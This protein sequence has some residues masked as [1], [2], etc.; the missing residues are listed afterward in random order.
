M[1]GYEN[2]ARVSY[3]VHFGI[4]CIIHGIF[5]EIFFGQLDRFISRP[6]YDTL[7]SFINRKS[8]FLLLIK[9][10]FIPNKARLLD[11]NIISQY[12]S[13]QLNNHTDNQFTA[14]KRIW[15][16]LI[17]RTEL[18]LYTRQSVQPLSFQPI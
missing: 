8:Q 3:I 15:N 7:N 12:H 16:R 4:K 1:C 5:H 14:A 17:T 10:I 11:E 2:D 9:I 6:K 13:K 18:C